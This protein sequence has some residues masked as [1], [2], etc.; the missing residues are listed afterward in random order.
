MRLCQNSRGCVHLVLNNLE[1]NASGSAP[2]DAST[3]NL[4]ISTPIISPT[5]TVITDLSTN[6]TKSLDEN[7]TSFL[8]YNSQQPNT[9]IAKE[10]QL[11]KSGLKL[12]LPADYSITDSDKLS[13]VMAT[14]PKYS[15]GYPEGYM[16]TTNSYKI[17]STGEISNEKTSCDY[18]RVQFNISSNEKTIKISD[19]FYVFIGCY[20][21][22][23]VGI[24]NNSDSDTNPIQLFQ[25]T[26]LDNPLELRVVDKRFFAIIKIA[27]NQYAT[28]ARDYS[29]TYR[30]EDTQ[31]T[32]SIN[33]ITKILETATK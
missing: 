25:T 26:F 7:I 24:A 30:N 2:I 17:T 13:Q 20:P 31:Q 27:D 12:V 23:L 5:P 1:N 6:E 18:D 15:E 19:S 9:E 16:D 28:I 10:V 11:T 32:D 4:Q 3:F 22:N 14:I 21:S 8:L 29:Y 33:L